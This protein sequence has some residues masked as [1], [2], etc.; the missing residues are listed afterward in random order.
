MSL[1]DLFLI[2]YNAVSVLLLFKA[3]S[4]TYAYDIVDNK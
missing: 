2:M 1:N 4:V 3:C